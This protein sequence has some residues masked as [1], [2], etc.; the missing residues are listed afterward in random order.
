MASTNGQGGENGALPA[1]RAPVRPQVHDSILSA[2]GETPLVRLP[3]G[4]EPGVECEIL[5]KVEFT[6][7]SGSIKD[8]I[9]LFMV[10]EAE[11]KG[12]LKPGGRIV[13]C[14]SGNTGAGLCLVA[15]ALGYPITIV[16][17][18]KMSQE[19]IDVLRAYGAEVVVTPANVAVDH[20]DHYTRKA[21]QIAEDT[22]GAWWPNQ[23]HNPD[24]TEGHYRST[25]AEIWR[26]CEGR[27]DAFVAGAGTGGSLAGVARYLKE[28]DPT[29]QVV[30]VDPPGSILADYWRTGELV[31][32]GFYFVE[33]VGEDEVPGA[34]DPEVV[35]DYR[36]VTDAVSFAMARRLA[37]AT[38]IFGGG[39]TGMNL[40]ATLDIA[41]KLP[42]EARVVTLVP[43]S[44]RAYLSKVYSED[45]LRDWRLLPPTPA[46]DATV[47]DLVRDGARAWVKPGETLYWAARH[48]GERGVRPLPVLEEEGGALLGVVDEA[49]VM[50]LLAAGE[51]LELLLVQDYIAEA[52]PVLDASAPWSE[53]LAVLAEQ[54]RVM[55]REPDGWASLER[56]DMLRALPRLDHGGTTDV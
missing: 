21:Q 54:E 56:R 42:A 23:Y 41:R 45:W 1:G 44:G 36:V 12:L 51:P 19:K 30:G 46:A 11:R 25:G 55:V 31:E 22:P 2:I 35:D 6:N 9:A 32:P 28:Q 5:L 29:V 3:A 43:D 15:A 10:R 50:E 8:R 34:W 13:E 14:S 37:L 26:Q 24:N 33:G 48:M 40:V 47:A 4:F 53:A 17:P 39:S 38:G 20:P 27:L 52:G 7:P 49:R 18:D 16:I